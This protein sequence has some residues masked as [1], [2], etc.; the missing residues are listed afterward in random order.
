ML[1]VQYG[2][3]FHAMHIYNP[4]SGEKRGYGFVD[5]VDESSTRKAL[6]AAQQSQNRFEVKGQRGHFGKYL[7]QKIKR[8][9]MYIEDRFGN[10]LLKQLYQKVPESGAH[11]NIFHFF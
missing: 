1:F 4:V 6:A 7:P 8:D 10:L 5:Y 9:L 11:K 3:V 2:Q